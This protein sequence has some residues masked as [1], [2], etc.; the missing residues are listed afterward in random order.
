MSSSSGGAG[1]RG[2]RE[3]SSDRCGA[4]RFTG[5]DRPPRADAVSLDDLASRDDL[6]SDD[7]AVSRGAVALR[8]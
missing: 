2:G 6:G 5:T 7:D 1:A 8:G 4:E 3:R